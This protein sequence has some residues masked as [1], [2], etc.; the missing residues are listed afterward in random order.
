MNVRLYCFRNSLSL[1]YLRFLSNLQCNYFNVLNYLK[2]HTLIFRRGV[3]DALFLISTCNEICAIVQS[4][5]V[6]LV[7]PICKG[8][9]ILTLADGTDRLF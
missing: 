5:V 2:L 3:I 7:G 4:K 9:E 8:K 6:N 1:C